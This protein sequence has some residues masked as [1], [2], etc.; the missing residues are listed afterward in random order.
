MPPL[1]RW[2][3]KSALVYF[4]VALFVGI[5]LAAQTLWKLPNQLA[6]LFPVY[7]HL[8]VLGWITQLIFGVV[9][10][11]FPKYSKDKPRASEGFGWATF[12][13][14]NTGLLLR[15]IAEPLN[16]G[17]SGTGWGWMLVLSAL[18]QWLAGIFFVLNTWGR[19]KEK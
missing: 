11:M 4:I 13:L 16:T 8:L 9:Y 18:L 5:L 14:L 2:F 7:L 15:A 19:V 17:Q 10:W 6:A 12:W 1:A 3:I